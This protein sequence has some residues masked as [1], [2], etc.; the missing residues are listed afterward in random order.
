M[1]YRALLSCC[2]SNQ[3]VPAGSIYGGVPPKFPDPTVRTPPQV[4]RTTLAGPTHLSGWPESSEILPAMTH[5]QAV[6]LVE[7]IGFERTGWPSRPYDIPPMATR[8]QT[9]TQG[10][11]DPDH[12]QHWP[13]GLA[14]VFPTAMHTTSYSA[15]DT[16]IDFGEA[17]SPRN[18]DDTDFPTMDNIPG[19]AAVDAT[20]SSDG[21]TRQLDPPSMT[22]P[23]AP[24][25]GATT[26][27]EREA[28]TNFGDPYSFRSLA[29]T[30]VVGSD[31]T[32]SP[33]PFDPVPRTASKKTPGAG[34]DS[35][36]HP[37][38]YVSQATKQLRGALGID[39]AAW[40]DG[41]DSSVPYSRRQNRAEWPNL[42][43]HHLQATRQM[44]G[45]L[46]PQPQICYDSAGWPYY[47]DADTGQCYP[48]GWKRD[49]P[50]E[51]LVASRGPQYA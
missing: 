12:E 35:P 13:S 26:E 5:R 10:R 2:R 21:S 40:S 39:G 11:T 25:P 3:Q 37:S 23:Q 15:R 28:W 8:S 50:R 46:K 27:Y 36:K 29:A 45:V 20:T 42:S 38:D 51:S 17:V 14:D 32:I 19:P 49:D 33:T 41:P 48:A 34:A 7:P 22:P 47:L 6:G 4:A 43:N 16:P 1:G 9:P 18:S 31:G 30:A 44:P 24:S